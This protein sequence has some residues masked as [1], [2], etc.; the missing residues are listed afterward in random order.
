[1]ESAARYQIKLTGVVQGVGFRPFVK[2]LAERMMLSGRVTNTGSGVL[3]EIE[4]TG[5]DQVSAF[6]V[7]LQSNAPPVARILSLS[8]N[9]VD[10]TGTM[11]GFEIGPSEAG[12]AA[13]TLLAPDLATCSD[14][15]R[16]IGDP[17]DRRFGYPFTNCTNCGPRYS[18][19]QRIPYD[20]ANTTMEAF[21]MCADCA[22]EYADPQDRRFHAEANACQVC[23]PRL[24]EPIASI[25]RALMD[26]EIVALKSLGGFQLACSA[27]SKQAVAKLRS[28]KNRGNK[29]FAVMM[30]DVETVR[31]HCLISLEE[32][33]LLCCRAAPIVLLRLRQPSELATAITPGLSE[34]GVM[35]PYTPLHYLLFG[36]SLSCLVMTSGNISDEPITISNEEAWNN[37][38]KL[39]DQ[40]TTHDR[41]IFTRV[42]DSVI[43]F[44]AG[45]PR[46]LRRARGYV[47]DPI[48]LG[49]E[50]TDVLACG[51]ELKSA[52]CI[53]KGR[54]AILSQHIGDLD[55]YETL[56]FYEETLRNLQSVYQSKPRLIAHDLHPDY[57]TSR[58]A[59]RH[60]LPKLPVQHHHAHIASCMAEHE[61]Q[62]RVIGVAFDGSGYGTDGQIWGGEFLLCEYT[63]F[64]RVGHLRPVPFIGGDRA[65][66][67]GFRMAAA[68][69]FDAVGG[70]YR[71]HALP[72]EIT[73][74][75][76]VFDRLM[77]KPS[78]MTSSCGR[79]FDAV[80]SL[81]GICQVNTY[82]GEAAMLL[83]SAAV[84]ESGEPYQFVIDA[85]GEIDTRP[86][87]RQMLEDI[88]GGRSAGSIAYRMH[89]TVSAMIGAAC[90]MIREASGV[91]KVCLSGG[92]FQNLILLDGATARLRATGFEVF[93]HSLIPANDGGLA[94]GQAVI[95]A[96]VLKQQGV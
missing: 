37:L 24:S 42:D 71:R 93:T 5:Q 87:F 41:E 33:A 36:G 31:S 94:L 16:E 49:Y 48:D 3:I 89:C 15:L 13:F 50:A 77:L 53:T 56:A 25:N 10:V 63:G 14:C 19:I 45:A 28:R 62:D 64:Q 61:L 40:V 17:A 66:R 57:L 55:N 88:A 74:L 2:T 47:P 12:A 72:A 54:Y 81:V 82:E 21:R 65:M 85:N 8:T 90:R 46:M 22:A 26:G 23:G 79:L 59:E 6:V 69:L 91:N 67:E 92:V 86:M 83:E 18:I 96:A 68:Y 44:H 20:R 76:A 70:N 1:M 29:P 52:F 80:A 9:V 78:L 43:R 27:F 32:E 34:V 35:L 38:G 39:A 60:P 95:A 11:T 73:R 51:G 58:W 75:P 84:E 4:A 7:A 30:A